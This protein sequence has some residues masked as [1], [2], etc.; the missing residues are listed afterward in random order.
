M[1]IKLGRRIHT[2]WHC[3]V[4]TKLTMPA[5]DTT[6]RLA[7]S[8]HFATSIKAELRRKESDVCYK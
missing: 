6:V 4:N 1:I 8:A 5:T 3:L 7:V 2:C